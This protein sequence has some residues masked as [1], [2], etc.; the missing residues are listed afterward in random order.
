MPITTCIRCRHALKSRCR[1]LRKA[2]SMFSCRGST[3]KETSSR[4]VDHSEPQRRS[5]C[6][7]RVR[8]YEFTHLIRNLQA[9]NS[10]IAFAGFQQNFGKYDV[11]AS[12]SRRTGSLALITWLKEIAIKLKLTQ[13]DTWPMV[14][15]NAIG[16]SAFIN[17]P[18][19]FGT[20][21][22]F[23]AHMNTPQMTLATIHTQHTMSLHILSEKPLVGE[24][25][26]RAEGIQ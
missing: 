25:A 13:A 4:G 17:L 18:S 22:N 7:K 12:R 5:A 10:L 21:C 14:W 11:K 3:H 2:W 16:K 24:S 19:T 23:V 9:A 6:S 20:G 1:R 15:N 26:V 8:I